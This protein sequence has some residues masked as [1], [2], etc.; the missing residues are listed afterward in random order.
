[1]HGL[2][3]SLRE[4]PICKSPMD[5]E[6]LRL[7]TGSMYEQIHFHYKHNNHTAFILTIEILNDGSKFPRKIVEIFLVEQPSKFYNYKL[8]SQFDLQ[9]WLNHI[10]NLPKNVT[11]L[12]KFDFS[13]LSKDAAFFYFYLLFYNI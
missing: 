6:A 1:M 2:S 9:L 4:F 10:D 3:D 12:G 8:P 11:L 7:L 13:N 5:I